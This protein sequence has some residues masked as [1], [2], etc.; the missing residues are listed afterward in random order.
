[1][2]SL[3][4]TTVLGAL[5][6][7]TPLTA[8]Q[9]AS[10]DIKINSN[11]LEAVVTYAANSSTN[12]PYREVTQ[13][14]EPIQKVVEQPKQEEIPPKTASYSKPKTTPFATAKPVPAA[15]PT[16]PVTGPAELE[17]LVEQYA[18]QYGA[19]KDIMLIIM[20]CESGY[21][22]NAS[23]GSFAGL[24]QFMASTWV[25]NRNAMGLDPNPA[26]RYNAEEAVKTA[27]FKMGRDGYGAWPACSAKAFAQ[28]GI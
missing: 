11:D 26:L 10:D 18:T 14:I 15:P 17:A 5:L 27:A 28:L 2:S 13:A 19:R 22:P 21:N 6:M 8:R 7:F 20:K 24:Y 4:T 16:G 25:S 12:N 23:N 1:M 9:T 3:L